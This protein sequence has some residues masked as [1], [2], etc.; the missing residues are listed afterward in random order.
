MTTIL[1]KAKGNSRVEGKDEKLPY[2]FNAAR[3]GNGGAP[4][5]VVVTAYEYNAPPAIGA[6]VTATVVDATPAAIN[7]TIITVP[8][9]QN[10]TPGNDYRIEVLWESSGATFEMWFVI[11]AEA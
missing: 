9:I 11:K 2:W 5:N 7:G 1:R 3:W 8:L 10:L 4:S 6:D